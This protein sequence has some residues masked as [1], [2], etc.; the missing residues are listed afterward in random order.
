MNKV[1]TKTLETERLI[2]RK[3]TLDDAKSYHNNWSIDKIT[4]EYDEIPSLDT[5]EKTEEHIKAILYRYEA[6]DNYYN[7]A[8]E[9]KSNH[10]VIGHIGSNK[11]VSNFQYTEIGYSLSSKYFK[12]G[13]M[14]EA[15]T[16]VID[17]Y[18]NEVGLRIIEAS[19]NSEN[20]ASQKLLLKVGFTLDAVLPERIV[21]KKTGKVCD[22]CIFSIINKNFKG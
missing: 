2:L 14:T 6:F 11:M 4:H 22:R 15:L 10:E 19:T 7:W 20:I 9:L 1:G 16:K 8:I 13:I 18:F 17:F 3:F 5:L 12:Q 21:S